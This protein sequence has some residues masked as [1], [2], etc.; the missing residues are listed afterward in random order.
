MR[1]GEEYMVTI[2][3][4]PE[5]ERGPAELPLAPAS[6]EETGL[7]TGM[8]IDL[9]LKTVYFAGNPSGADLVKRLALPLG[10]VQQLLGFLRHEHLCEVTGGSGTSS[11]GSFR[12]ALTAEGA[13]RAGQALEFAG[14]V[15]PAPVPL[16]DYIQQVEHQSVRRQLITKEDIES[17]LSH[18][19]LSADTLG[20]LGRAVSSGKA[21]LVYGASGDGKTTIAESLRSA[22]GG[23]IVIPYA[24]EVLR[25]IIRLYDP[26]CHEAVD[27]PVKRSTSTVD[28]RWVV[29]RRPSVFA[30]G[31]LAAAHL[32]LSLDPVQKTYEAPIQ[33]K[34][35]G[36]LLI[37]DD[38]GRQQLQ[39]SYLLSRW[40][41]PLEQGVDTLTLHTGARFRV[42][43]DAIP[44]FSTNLQPSSLA[45]DAFLR[46]IRY[47]VEIPNPT[48]QE[49]LEILRRECR[50]YEVAYR[51]DG[52]QHLVQRHYLDTG[53]EMRG[54]QPRDIVEA[55][56]DSAR[57]N[58]S[59]RVLSPEAV[60]QA[61]ASY[62]V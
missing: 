3:I 24:V 55:V 54:C 45:D 9:V 21:T 26:A 62:F 35:N 41:V 59:L 28:R 58:G 4:L 20:R 18:L 14:Y 23:N 33:M 46:R 15:G 27:A 30:A 56:A 51:Q 47:K 38:F 25:Q 8:L 2:A 43:F 42:P 16:A 49:F 12:Y 53:R 1:E 17:S 22:L 5:V 52:A 10:V 37:I 60:D 6:V 31:E 19:V 61:A 40:I 50:K 32:E 34:A 39:A 11:S 7:D 13:L 36:G 57:Y 44:I 29:I 48:V